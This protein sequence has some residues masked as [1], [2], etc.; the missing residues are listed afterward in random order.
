MRRMRFAA[1]VVLTA[2]TV[3]L[4]AQPAHAA[5]PPY[6]GIPAGGYCPSGYLCAHQGYYGQG[7]GVGFYL[8]AWDWGA[9]PSAYRFINNTASSL[10]NHGFGTYSFVRAFEYAGGTGVHKCLRPGYAVQDLW[11]DYL[12]NRISAHVWTSGCGSSPL[13]PDQVPYF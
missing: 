10:Y 7:A 2:V 11:Y 9:I 8:D 5:P 13:F 4:T 6:I 3:V 12:D 1:A